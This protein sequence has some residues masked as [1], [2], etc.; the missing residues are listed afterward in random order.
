[1]SFAKISQ[2]DT[3]FLTT[4]GEGLEEIVVPESI[5]NLLMKDAYKTETV[6]KDS[7]DREATNLKFYTQSGSII[8]TKSVR[9][10]IERLEDQIQGLQQQLDKLKTRNR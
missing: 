8:I 7:L 4:T 5:F 2:L 10:E 3:Y 1:M 9:Q 6:P